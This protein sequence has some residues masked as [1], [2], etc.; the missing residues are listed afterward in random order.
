MQGPIGRARVTTDSVESWLRTNDKAG[1]DKLASGQALDAKAL[2][3]LANGLGA[4]ATDVSQAITQ[5]EQKLAKEAKSEKAGFASYGV[6]GFGGA[7]T[8]QGAKSESAL[9]RFRFEGFNPRLDAKLDEL[10]GGHRLAAQFPVPLDKQK[11][12][13]ALK[14]DLRDVPVKLAN[15]QVGDVYTKLA[16]DKSL[17][18]EQKA[19]IFSVLAEVRDNYLRLDDAIAPGEKNKGYQVVNWKHTRGEI[20]QVLEAAKLGK[21]TPTQTEDALLASIFSDAVKTPQN[22]ITHNID[23]AYAAAEVLSRHLDPKKDLARLEGII[24]AVKE[25]Q[26]GPPAFM[27]M[28]MTG[29]LKGKLGK[30][31]AAADLENVASIGKKVANPL[32]PKNQ[33]A[34][35]SELAFS[36]AE[37]AILSKLGVESWAV[38]NPKSAHHKAS[39]AVIDGDSLINYASPD[40]WAKIVAIRGPDTGPFFEDKVVFDSVGSAK[41]SYDDAYSV[42]SDA[43]KPLARQG[44]ARTDKSLERVRAKMEKFLEA[45]GKDV[46]YDDNGKVPFWNTPLKYPSQ[47]ELSAKE[48]QQF[49]FAKQIR[50][51]FVGLLRAEQ[52]IYE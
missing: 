25:H 40:G 17:S 23:G 11:S 16:T 12:L 20:D 9:G 39:R 22:F 52:G 7:T 4:S 24:G 15:G 35:R 30:E 1:L 38:P 41:K 3:G 13:A 27:S 29:M 2:A 49:E 43:A 44:L 14:A 26:I 46:P 8:F 48:K 28:I 31:A 6:R 32:D 37:R 5:L 36:P 45:K 51:E 18:K 10:T 21:L 47:G 19:R 33:T 42:L 34:D 50:E